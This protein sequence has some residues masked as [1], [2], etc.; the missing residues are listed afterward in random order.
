MCHTHLIPFIQIPY[1]SLINIP[2]QLNIFN[3]LVSMACKA[4]SCGTKFLSTAFMNA[5][6]KPARLP[7]TASFQY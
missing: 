7:Y 2:N 6:L 5:A 4:T 1:S 3:C